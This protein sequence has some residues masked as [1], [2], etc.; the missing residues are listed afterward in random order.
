M[1]GSSRRPASKPELIAGGAMMLVIG[2]LLMSV[3]L[4]AERAPSISLL[5]LIGGGAIA[6]F[7]TLGGLALLL[8]GLTRKP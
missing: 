8:Q 7:V 1:V 6:L 2:A 4:L 5:A 3:L